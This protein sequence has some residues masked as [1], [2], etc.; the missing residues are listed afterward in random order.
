MSFL[1]FGH[2]WKFH[3][4]LQAFLTMNWF[5]LKQEHLSTFKSSVY[6]GILK[7][8]IIQ[9]AYIYT[10]N[11]LRDIYFPSQY[12]KNDF[13]FQ[14]TTSNSIWFSR[15]ILLNLQQ[16]AGNVLLICSIT[17]VRS[18]LVSWGG[19]NK[20]SADMTTKKSFL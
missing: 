18:V 13:F 6:W 20:S 2:C 9:L 7:D 16:Q 5:H 10:R 19:T 1:L 14:K 17:S 4:E 8:R 3:I 12:H 15:H 11:L